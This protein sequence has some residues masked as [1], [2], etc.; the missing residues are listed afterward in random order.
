MRRQAIVRWGALVGVVAEWLRCWTH[1]RKVV[2]SN[3]GRDMDE[4][5]RSS[6]KPLPHPTQVL[7]G[8][9]AIGDDG[10]CRVL[11][12]IRAP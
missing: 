6:C 1:A 10:D 9:L 5:G 7:K 8:Y 4:L 11:N 12:L 3:P 2:G